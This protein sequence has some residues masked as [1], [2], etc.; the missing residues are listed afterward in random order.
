MTAIDRLLGPER[1]R[2]RL[3]ARAPP[4]PLHDCLAVPWPRRGADCR[5]VP[6]LAV[7]LE[8]TGL[9]P[10]HDAIVA[11]GWI[12]LDGRAIDL[13]SARHLVVAPGREIPAPSAVVHG[14]GDD[15][16]ARG[17]PIAE[18]LAELLRDAAGKVLVAH[19]A[20]FEVAALDGAC[21]RAFGAP[22]EPMAVDTLALARGWLEKRS[23]AAAREGPSL[24]LD[25]VR[26]RHN[27]PRYRAHHALSDALA[28][29]ELFLAQLAARDRGHG[30]P[31]RTVLST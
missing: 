12:A 30:I 15:A 13:G 29:A 1:R 11:I 10:V 5:D 7:D 21:R 17:V 25:A 6:F 22:F 31:L 14:I 19:N 24:R 3:L 26:R 16:A 8:T 27:L 18:A 23:A 2:R 28:A 4:G 20:R 9:D